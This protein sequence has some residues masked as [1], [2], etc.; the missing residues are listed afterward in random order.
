MFK[1]IMWSQGVE[2]LV[3][4]CVLKCVANGRLNPSNAQLEK[5]KKIHGLGGLAYEFKPCISEELFSSL[6]GFS[7]DRNELAHRAAD[8]YMVNAL[9]GMSEE[10]IKG[11]LWKLEE[12]TKMAG[13]LYGELLD[14]H[15]K[16]SV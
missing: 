14:L 10:E 15:T 4:D 2:N 7:K 6:L 13:D 9:V 1:A 5:I 16:F 3:R 11:E 12:N 8:T